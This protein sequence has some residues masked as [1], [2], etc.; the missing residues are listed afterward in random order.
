VRLD[1]VNAITGS[2]CVEATL[3][4]RG[5]CTVAELRASLASARRSDWSARIT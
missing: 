5:V 1:P 3:E 2:T 4:Q